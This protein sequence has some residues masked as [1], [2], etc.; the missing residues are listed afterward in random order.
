[1]NNL[2]NDHDNHWI[3]APGYAWVSDGEIWTTDIYLGA[4]DTIDRWHGTN[5]EPPEPIEPD[6]FERKR[7]AGELSENTIYLVYEEE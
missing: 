6:E 3:P 1:M 2:S 4:S 5:D 7:E